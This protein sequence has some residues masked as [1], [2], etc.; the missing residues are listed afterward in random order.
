MEEGLAVI[1]GFFF[2]FEVFEGEGIGV[3]GVDVD[4]ESSLGVDGG[5]ELF[6]GFC[7]SE[8]V[9]GFF[10]VVTE[11]LD[12]IEGLV[13]EFFV[14]DGKV[15]IGLGEVLGEEVEMFKE[16]GNDDVAHTESESREVNLTIRDQADEVIIS[17]TTSDGP[18]FL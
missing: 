9:D 5:F 11:P 3:E 8:R 4:E 2:G 13:S 16:F 6:I 7:R 1:G 18:E 12:G 17:A 10:A 14:F 15:D